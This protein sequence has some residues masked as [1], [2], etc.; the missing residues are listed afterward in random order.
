MGICLLT[1]ALYKFKLE[2]ELIIIT[3]LFYFW[4]SETDIFSTLKKAIG[5]KCKEAM[6]F[7]IT[8][9]IPLPPKN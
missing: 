8:V 6:L 9:A 2:D 1:R 5:D 4:Y 3:R 7:Y